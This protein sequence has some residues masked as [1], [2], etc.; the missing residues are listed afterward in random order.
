[1][2]MGA[3]GPSN[4]ALPVTEESARV[5]AH[6]ILDFPGSDAVEVVVTGSGSGVTR[7]A[8]SQIIQNVVRRDSRAYVR[9]VARGRRATSSTNQLDSDHMKS[10]AARA[11][12]AAQRS[13]LDPDWPGLPAAA[14][15]PTAVMRLDE[16]TASASPALRASAV[17]DMIGATGDA[18]AAGFF[19]TGAH[20]YAVFSSS[21]IDCY[22]A[23]SR[24]IANCLCDAGEST[25]W[26]DDSSTAV[27]DVDAGAIGL[28]AMDK[29]QAGRSAAAVSAGSYEVVLEPRAVWDL[30]D[31]LAYSGFG[32]KQVIEGE[33]FLAAH[34]GKRVAAETVTLTDDVWHPSSVGIGFDFEGV[35]KQRVA[36]ID[37]G[38]AR[39]P[40]TDTR[41]AHALETDSTGHASGS[42]EYGPYASNVVLEPGDQSLEDL[43]AG[44]RDGLLITRF[45][46]V[47][48]LDRRKT[49]LTGM[50]KDG[51]FRIRGGEIGPAV[52]NLRFTQSVLDTLASVT[53]IGR[54]LASFAPE[55]GTFGSTVAPALRTGDFRFTSTTDH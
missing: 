52:H 50:T 12:E 10:A 28:K 32:A 46:Y 30:L 9:V 2:T 21:G 34:A 22:D 49:L 26:G 47:N 33:S 51:T 29:A 55:F 37:E 19:E 18:R 41:T 8:N 44:V 6:A 45:H 39:G 11:L 15:R 43:V 53:G 24:C 7:F 5:A 42:D 3:G 31:L 38:I 16:A 13:P 27:A 25:G 35:S 4:G 17:R 40:V 14:A 20:A 1:M 54:D 23:Y 48:I 36:V